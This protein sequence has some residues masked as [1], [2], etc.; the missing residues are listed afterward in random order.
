M[1]PA[2]SDKEL[3]GALDIARNFGR[4][5]A[6]PVTIAILCLKRRDQCFWRCKNV[7]GIDRIFEA[8][9]DFGIP[10]EW[11]G[12][13]TILTDLVNTRGYGEVEQMIHL[14]EALLN[15]RHGRGARSRQHLF[16]VQSDVT[17]DDPSDVSSTTPAQ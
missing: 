5:Y 2:I 7:R 9:K 14:L 13:P 4:D 8:L 16:G 10:Q 15:Y 3:Q 6:V 17:M 1:F 12:D 11:C